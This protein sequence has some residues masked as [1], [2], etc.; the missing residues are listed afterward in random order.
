MLHTYSLIQRLLRATLA[1]GALLVATAAHAQTIKIEAENPANTLTGSGIAVATDITPFSGTGYVN[2]NGN[3]GLSLTIPVTA[4]T[5]G[6]YNLIIRYESQYGTTQAGY[7]KIG[8]YNVNGGTKNKIYFNGTAPGIAGA[9]Y[10]STSNLRV[11]LNAGSNTIAIFDNSYGYFGIDYIQLTP[12]AATTGLTLSAAGRV[13]AEAGQLVGVQSLVRDDDMATYSGTGY[14]SSFNDTSPSAS[15]LVLPITITTAGV[16]QVN[17][18]ARGQFDG[19]SFDVAVNTGGKRT[20][21]VPT[22]VVGFTSYM[23]ANYALTAG[24]NTI[25]ITSQTGYLDVDYVDITATTGTVTAV[26]ASAG[27]QQAL[28]A[29]PNPTNG[30]ALTV[31]LELA[32]AQE[33]TFDLVNALGQRVSSSTCS[34]RAGSNSLQ[35][36][37]AGLASGLYQLVARSGDQPLLVQRVVVN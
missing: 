8:S 23:V 25:T 10:K 22:A 31:G 11:T 34:L 17:V 18:G 2:F 28:V 36:S 35:L 33:T 26:R 24:L 6:A 37:T 7:G 27:A 9:T 13:E 21:Q 32:A 3:T 14:V 15:A 12:A 4:T 5:A 19:K 20:T 16:Y 30:Q 1:A 29:Y